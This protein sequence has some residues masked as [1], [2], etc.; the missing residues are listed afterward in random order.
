MSAERLNGKVAIVTA[1]AS[2]I[3]KATAIRYAAEGAKV[4][5]VDKDA[6]NGQA[7]VDA[8]KAAGGDAELFVTDM[9]DRNQVKAM[10]A[11]VADKYGKIDILTNCVGY[12]FSK[13]FLECTD[14]DWWDVMDTNVLANIYAMWEV[15]PYMQKQKKG[16]IV[17]VV[18]KLGAI[19]PNDME[20]FYSF[21]AGAMTM[22]S[23]CA[24]LDLV[25]DGIRVNVVA[26]GFTN[27]PQ[28]EGNERYAKF[29]EPIAIPM[30]RFAEPEEVANV[31][32]FLASDEASYVSGA[33]YEVDGGH[34]GG[35]HVTHAD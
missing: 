27:T 9:K 29:K 10:A 2:G 18:S 26:P 20:A 16:S 8:I 28:T 12:L 14:E 15:V 21:A 34:V 13:P 32:L 31:A 24:Q 35:E 23:K 5:V 4:A 3:G 17:N 22:V 19:R 33:V 30:G 7:V 6:E 25:K 11:A 1:A